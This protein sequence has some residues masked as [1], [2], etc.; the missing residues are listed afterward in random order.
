MKKHLV[1]FDIRERSALIVILIV[2]W[3]G[4]NLAFTFLVNVPRA[5][6]IAA[7]DES[8]TE[9]ASVQVRTQKD[10]AR[11]MDQRTRVAEGRKAMEMFYDDIISTKQERLISF[12]KEIRDIAAKFNINLETVSYPR[13]VYPKNKVIKFGATMPLTGSYESLRDFIDTIER[14]PNF[15]AIEAIQLTNSKEGGV[16]LSLSIQLATWFAD[17]DLREKPRTAEAGGRRG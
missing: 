13:E 2:A 8:R 10:V 6:E 14:S 16:I 7:L 17:P 15:I 3:L 12:Q 4:L 11:L 9:R 5:R 1:A